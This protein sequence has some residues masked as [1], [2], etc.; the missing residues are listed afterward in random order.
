MGTIAVGVPMWGDVGGGFD[1]WLPVYVVL[2][3]ALV[4]AVVGW[5]LT[6]RRAL[7]ALAG[8]MTW[9]W[10]VNVLGVIPAASLAL[11]IAVLAGAIVRRRGRAT[12]AW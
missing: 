5:G 4:M 6:T 10:A 11:V 9:S 12:R 1:V 2:S 3:F 8:G 7:V